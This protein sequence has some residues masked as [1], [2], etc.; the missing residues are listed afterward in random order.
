MTWRS[1]ARPTLHAKT[2]TPTGGAD[3]REIDH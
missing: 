3:V 2:A 1:K